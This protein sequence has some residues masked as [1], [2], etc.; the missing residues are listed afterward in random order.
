MGSRFLGS[1][2]ELNRGTSINDAGQITGFA[3]VWPDAPWPALP[4]T[5]AFLLTPV[6]TSSPVIQYNNNAPSLA[7][8]INTAGAGQAL[9]DT[10]VLRDKRA[11]VLEGIKLATAAKSAVIKNAYTGSQLSNGWMSPLPT[12]YIVTVNI[13]ETN[14]DITITYWDKV[15]AGSPT[16][17]LSP[18]DGGNDLVVGKPP[19]TGA[20][21]WECNS[22]NP[23]KGSTGRIGTLEAE[24]VPANCRGL[25]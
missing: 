8:P 22:A 21:V 15:S 9:T 16:L 14:G 18:R 17:V 10:T 7:A 1:G 25:R 11:A 13:N 4:T 23:P 19:L 2:W 24:L 12:D 5:H 6:A 20:I 3:T